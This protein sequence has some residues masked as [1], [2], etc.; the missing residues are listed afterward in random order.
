MADLWRETDGS[1]EARIKKETAEREISVTQSLKRSTLGKSASVPHTNTVQAMVRS[2]DTIPARNNG[3]L[4]Q[5]CIQPFQ[6]LR[7]E[8][9]YLDEPFVP[10]GVK[11]SN[12]YL[13]ELSNYYSNAPRCCPR[14]L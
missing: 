5:T 6:S 8:V 10:D 12:G 3:R 2:E 11:S 13:C 1:G 4:R 7:P 14:L 9:C